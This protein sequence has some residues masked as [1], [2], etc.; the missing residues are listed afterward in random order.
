[1]KRQ[2]KF[3][4]HR[5]STHGFV[6]LLIVLAILTIGG[7]SLLVILGA[8]ATNSDRQIQ[9][10]NV[11]S[12]ILMAAKQAL[13][14]YSLSPPPSLLITRPGM[15]PIP[16]SLSNAIYDGKED[17]LCLG[18][19]VNGLP[20][21]NATSVVKRCV[22][23]L[24]WKDLG[25]DIGNSDPHDP[26]GQVP[27]FAVSAN[28][29]S[30]DACLAV[31]NSEIANLNSPVTS[32]CAPGVWPYPQPVALPHPWL[33]VYDQNGSLLSDKV[34]IVLIM[35]GGPIAT[36][37]RTQS[38]SVATVGNPSDYLD[39]ISVPLGCTVGCTVLDNGGL[40]NK[41]V[42]IP[43][44]TNY[45]SN[46]A[47]VALRNQLVP[48]NDNLIYVTIDE[49]MYYIERRVLGEMAKAMQSFKAQPVAIGLNTLPWM[50][51][52][53]S[54]FTSSTSLY[55]LANTTFGAFPFMIQYP[56][57]SD[58]PFY[59]SDF[60]WSLGGASESTY[61]QALN[62]S[63][64]NPSPCYQIG[65]SPNRYLRNPL[66]DTLNS[67]TV[68]GGPFSA[69]STAISDGTCKWLG[70]SQVYCETDLGVSN[71]PVTLYSTLAQCNS[72]INPLSDTLSLN[73]KVILATECLS[74]KVPISNSF[75]ANSTSPHRRSWSC[76]NTNAPEIVEVRYVV[77]NSVVSSHN[78]LP[79]QAK[80]SS[81]GASQNF[82]LS[83]V[84]DHP[85]MPVWF[86]DNRWY[87][88]AFA[89]LAPVS[90]VA[91]ASPSPNPCT[92]TTT[93][94]VGGTP[95]NS[96]IVM[97]AGKTV[98]TQTRPSNTI[99]D[100]FEGINTNGASSCSFANFATPSPTPFN[101]SLLVVPP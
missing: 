14:G 12:N 54:I 59:R 84:L 3:K 19:T 33:S 20:G 81:G 73:R 35:P 92:P 38:R 90:G 63:G 24:P 10:N 22:G 66:I 9:Q 40:T 78:R 65:N 41:F 83:N 39:S 18:N 37:T 56:N 98:S 26:L 23:K 6:L 57:S 77:S 2:T 17:N 71:V 64:S 55:S 58:Y 31:L 82:S 27:W 68:F 80:L 8:R 49:L 89:A 47:N 95:G 43:S 30:Y 91:P 7:V 76:N 11:N 75:S 101:D 60:A 53:S 72:Q 51:P 32:T 46:A 15:L 85:L 87:L 52:L 44:G 67:S 96:A 69:G 21:V 74:P 25:L 36:E 88:I 100:Y 79:R 29:V 28:L 13:I 97:L 70:K 62:G 61:W 86:Y 93:L 1:M 45:P 99:V 42:K 5:K 48:F 34:A 50:Q 4:A 94:I 16:D